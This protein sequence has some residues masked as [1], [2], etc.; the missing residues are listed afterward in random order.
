MTFQRSRILHAALLLLLPFG[1]SSCQEKDESP[2]QEYDDSVYRKNPYYESMLEEYRSQEHDSVVVVFLGDSHTHG[3]D[4]NGMLGRDDVVNRGIPGDQVP[5]FLARVDEALALE[6]DYVF[7]MGG[8]NDIYSGAPVERTFDA[9]VKLI[10]RIREAGA[11]PVVQTT[12]FV[13]SSFQRGTKGNED[14]RMLNA[15][16]RRYADKHDVDVIE[17][18]AELCENGEL[19]REYSSDGLH[20]NSIGYERWGDLVRAYFAEKGI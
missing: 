2:K 1:V 4:W 12:L 16:L 3:A 15:R 20:L 13:N 18:V 11:V 17:T 19:I 6:P 9:Y 8:I 10:E 14:V 5:G 7:I